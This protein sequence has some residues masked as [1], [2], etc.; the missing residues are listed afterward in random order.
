MNM[1]IHTLNALMRIINP[2]DSIR[3]CAPTLAASAVFLTLGVCQTLRADMILDFSAAIGVTVG[4]NG[5]VTTWADQ[6]LGNG[7]QNATNLDGV[8]EVNA[9]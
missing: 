1:N 5:H 9:L 7:A 6:A 4:V 2:R 8:A 3:Q